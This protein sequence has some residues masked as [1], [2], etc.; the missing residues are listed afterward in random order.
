VW[1][2]GYGFEDVGIVFRFPV[3]ANI[4]LFPK[5][6][7]CFR[8][9]HIVL[10]CGYR[11]HFFWCAVAELGSLLPS[12]TEVK[13]V[14]SRALMACIRGNLPLH[15]LCIFNLVFIQTHKTIRITTAFD[16]FIRM[17]SGFIH[18]VLAVGVYEISF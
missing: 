17:W 1:R 8:I 5:H 12:G 2:L 10:F 13:N 18:R 14:L 11:R 9:P 16:I 3:F 6:P 7:N 15:F 4:S